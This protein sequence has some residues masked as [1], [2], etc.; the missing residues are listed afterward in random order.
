MAS[1]TVGLMKLRNLIGSAPKSTSS[2][3]RGLEKRVGAW[4]VTGVMIWSFEVSRRRE[5]LVEAAEKVQLS[6]A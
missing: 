4:V 6:A 1:P 2:A 3:K 5:A